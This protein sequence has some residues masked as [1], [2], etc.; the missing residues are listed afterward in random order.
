MEVK[1]IVS[2]KK[3]IVGILAHVLVRIAKYL[4]SI[5]DTSVITCNE[6]IFVMDIVSTKMTNTIATNVLINS[7]DKK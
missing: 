3:I 5:A 4:K 2:T 1:I 6:I 7:N